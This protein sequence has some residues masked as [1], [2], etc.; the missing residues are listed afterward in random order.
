MHA[1]ASQTLTF[2]SSAG[3]SLDLV[4]LGVLAGVTCL[5]VVAY[6]A[7]IPYP[8]LLVVGGGALAFVPGLPDVDLDPDLVLVVLLP[9]LLYSAAFFSSLRDLRANLAPIGLLAVGLVIATTLTVGLVAHAFINDLSWAA[10]FTL[11]AVLSPTDPV[12]ATAIASRAGAPRRFVTIVE[13]E[14]LLNDSSGLIIYKAAVAATLTGTFSLLD[15]GLDFVV[16][17][18]AGIAIG[19]V[20]GMIVARVRRVVDDPPTEITISLMTP[21]FAYLP[22]E[23]LGVSAVLA[24]VTIG[25]WLGWR[26][27]ELITPAVRIQSFSVWEILTFVLNAALF[28]L[29]GLQLPQIVERIAD[30]YA[31]ADLVWWS[32]LVFTVVV[33]TRFAWVA[34]ATYVPRLW[35]KH[36]PWDGPDYKPG[37]VALVGWTGMRGAVSLAAA[38][39]IPLTVD[40]GAPF[41]GRDLIIFLVYVTIL[42]TL[43]V[44]GL[45]LAPLIRLLGV[46]DDGRL[47]RLEAKARI[48]AARRAIGRIDELQG[49]DWVRDVSAQR[50]RNSYEFRIRRFGSR[51][52][53]DDDGADEARSQAYQLLRRE[54][55]EAER[56][57]IIR[58]RNDGVINDEV[59]RRI[60]HDLDLE[61]ARLDLDGRGPLDLAQP[62]EAESE[63]DARIEHDPGPTPRA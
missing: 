20:V 18:A 16:G 57:E 62:S 7:R 25:I 48:K 33:V 38:L 11:G 27:P 54:V 58:L 59:L 17:A 55:L 30:K 13:G 46:E 31:V 45:S 51:F 5:L 36:S 44:E 21:Y 47:D 42:A 53:D 43:L 6:H 22:A 37:A 50:L 9:P 41:P 34:V 8:I 24:A 63:E 15:S 10:A 52:D 40:G 35:L 29:V 28:V 32:A 4:L 49:E 19:I 61:D 12:A 39:A 14:S 56:A 1:V 26:A 2:A 23:A 60:Q 3:S